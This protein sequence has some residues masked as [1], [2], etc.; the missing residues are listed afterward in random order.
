MAW[1]N[2]PKMTMA[3]MLWDFVQHS[4]HHQLL[5][6]ADIRDFTIKCNNQPQYI[7]VIL[8]LLN[9]MKTNMNTIKWSLYRNDTNE[10]L[11]ESFKMLLFHCRQHNNQFSK[12]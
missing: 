7:F 4:K 2:R 1:P 5:Q 6:D 12:W 3:A 11:N 9:I 10:L 8:L